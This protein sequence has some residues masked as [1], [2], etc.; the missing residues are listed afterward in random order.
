VPAV[1]VDDFRGAFL[2]TEHLL[3]QG[4]KRVAHIA[5]Q[6]HI[7]IFSDRLAGY[8]EALRVYDMPFDQSLVEFGTVSIESGRQA[9]AQFLSLSNK[10]DA[11]FAVED[12]T[13]LGV[14]KELKERDINIPGEFGVVGFANE[15]FGEHIT[16]SLSTIDQQTVQMGKEAFK[17]LLSLINEKDIKERIR[18]K[19]VLDAV[20]V[21]RQSSSRKGI[22]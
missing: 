17:L 3:K 8:K 19:V 12:F 9:A 7:K 21:F 14:I 6:Q 10:P 16:P 18:M 20:P 2:A 1:V 22:K 4:Y 13:A 11:I 5:G 15:L